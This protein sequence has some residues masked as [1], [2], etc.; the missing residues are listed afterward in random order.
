MRPTVEHGYEIKDAA[1]PIQEIQ[2]EEKKV[3]IQG[4]YLRLE[5]KELRNGSTLYTFN[6]TDFTDSLSSKIFGKIK[7][8]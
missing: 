3:T 6:L 7:K 4:R 2:E 8:I 1:V 5:T